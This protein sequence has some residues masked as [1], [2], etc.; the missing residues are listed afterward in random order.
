MS[1]ITISAENQALSNAMHEAV[2]AGGSRVT[3]KK[4]NASARL[5][6][7]AE[8]AE[9][10]RLAREAS[11]QKHVLKVPEKEGDINGGMDDLKSALESGSLDDKLM[12]MLQQEAKG[13]GFKGGEWDPKHGLEMPKSMTPAQLEDQIRAL[14][15]EQRKQQLVDRVAKAKAEADL[16][17]ALAA[18]E[19]AVQEL[20]AEETATAQTV[21]KKKKKNKK[22]KKKQAAAVQEAPAPA[23]PEAKTAVHAVATKAK[24]APPAAAPPAPRGQPVLFE[25]CIDSVA[26]GVAAQAGGA[27]R[28]ELCDNLVDGGTTPSLGTLTVL[29]KRLSIPIHVL[30]RPRGGDFLYSADEF[31][32]MCSDIRHAKAAGADGVVLGMLLAD[33]QVDVA[34]TT[35]LIRIAREGKK[36]LAV[37]FH[38]AFDMTPDLDR[39][40]A[41]CGAMK[42]DAILSSG[43]AQSAPAGAAVLKRMVAAEVVHGFR[44]MAGAGVTEGNVA[45]LVRATG[46]TAVHA[47]GRSTSGSGMQFRREGVFMG[48]EKHNDASTEFSVRQVDSARVKGFVAAIAGAQ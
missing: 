33:G 48:A 41:D 6:E 37:T 47:S 26:S 9:A 21:Q 22:N 25:V 45:A 30:I 27:G 3:S 5:T 44:V 46:V 15:R 34:R 28:V 7:K 19:R 23:E 11:Q 20:E 18:S 31:E 32:V 1:S 14:D 39:A 10:R 16:K 4:V 8:K 24:Q 38:R 35:Q 13:K 17:E 29:R 12:E 36:A 43:Q 40:L 2:K 42:V